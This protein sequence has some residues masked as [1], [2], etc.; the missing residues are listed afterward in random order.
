[1][2]DITENERIFAEDMQGICDSPFI[3]WDKLAGMTVFVTGATGLVGWNLVCAL[4]YVSQKLRLNLKILAL[5][6]D[7]ARA[8]E[9]FSVFADSIG[10]DLQFIQGTAEQ[11]ADIDGDID[12]IVHGASPTASSFFSGHPAETLSIAF[13]GTQRALE[14]AKAKQVRAFVYLSSMEIYGFPQKGHK[15]TERDIGAFL[16]DDTRNSYPISKLAAESLCHAYW[17]EY[18]VPAK[19]VRLTQTFG[20]GASRDDT[21][22]FAYMGRCIQ[23]KT[24]IVLKTAGETERSYL[25][26]ADAVTAILTVLLNGEPGAA[27]NAADE[28]T[29]CSIADMAKK[30]AA[31]AGINVR[32]EI[33][34]VQKNGYP[35]TLYMDLDTGALQALGWRAQF[36]LRTMGGGIVEMLERMIAGWQTN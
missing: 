10:K 5:V 25:Y 23:E 7:S 8:Q 21:R 2:E 15:V 9:R 17:A 28:T 3:D 11:L 20:P 4:L 12:Y 24:D 1:M 26:T 19:I 13:S 6:R 35:A 30:A 34:N 14:L 33:E 36:P 27:Y 32:F 18:G 16:P 31:A 22:I 29:Y